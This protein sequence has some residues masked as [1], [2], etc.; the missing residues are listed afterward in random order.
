MLHEEIST[1]FEKSYNKVIEDFRLKRADE[2]FVSP[3]YLLKKY[4]LN[5]VDGFLKIQRLFRSFKI[6]T[7]GLSVFS[8]GKPQTILRINN[9]M[10]KKRTTF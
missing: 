7:K 1:W 10:M 4:V 8:I 2:I 5:K 9:I 6:N 3:F